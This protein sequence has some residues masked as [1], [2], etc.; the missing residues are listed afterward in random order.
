VSITAPG[1]FRN[2]ISGGGDLDG[3][4][5]NDIVI[6]GDSSPSSPDYLSLILGRTTWPASLD[7]TTADSANGVYKA[8]VLGEV[9][10]GAYG[11]I[12]GDLDQDGRDDLVFSAGGSLDQVYVLYGAELLS[13][14]LGE[15]YYPFGSNFIQLTNPCSTLP[16][17][18][19]AAAFG[20]YI[21]GGDVTGDS[22]PEVIIGNRLNKQLIVL[23]SDLAKIDCFTRGEDAFGVVFDLA[24]DINE[25]GNQDLISTHS[26][27]VSTRAFVFFN[28]GFGT[29]GDDVAVTQR[30]PSIR[31]LDPAAI[32]IAVSV[33][34]DLNADSRDDVIFMTWGVSGEPEISVL[35]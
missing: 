10:V 14:F 30:A 12:V 9:N 31:L 20:T 19:T 3:D 22:R 29:F 1:V 32:K 15:V 17:G 34:G 6:G 11:H 35:Y 25:D 24:G 7:S 26:D 8:Y 18:A 2:S 16:S 13:E 28:D 5:I 27:D 33:A 4:G 23:D 21:R